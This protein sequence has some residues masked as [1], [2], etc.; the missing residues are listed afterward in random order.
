[1]TVVVKKVEA[2]VAV[3]VVVVVVGVSQVVAVL[4]NFIYVMNV[5]VR[6]TK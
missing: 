4:L 2:A 1:M 5:K 6:I 3:E